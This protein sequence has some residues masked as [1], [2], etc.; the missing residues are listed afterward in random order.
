MKIYTKGGDKGT[1]ALIG[2]RRVPKFHAKIEAYGTVDELISYTGLLRDEYNNEHYK[3]VLIEIQDRL[4]TCSSL[5]A[6]DCDG[7]EEE[8]PQIREK[9]IDF[10]EKEIDDMEKDLPPLRSF[11]LPGGNR[12]VSVCHITRTICRRAE[13]ITI[14]LAEEYEVGELVIKY[15]N[16]LSDFFFVFSRLISRDL[17]AEEIPWKPKL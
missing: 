3:A 2:G 1:T 12:V 17:N 14:K 7:C 11:I 16:R 5:L 9:D 6:A 13:R 4:M 8:L 10:L 15:L